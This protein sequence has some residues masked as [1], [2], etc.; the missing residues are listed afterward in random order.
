[1]AL[2]RIAPLHRRQVRQGNDVEPLAIAVIGKTKISRDEEAYLQALGAA[3]VIRGA[4][5]I[6]TD[7]KGVNTAVLAGAKTISDARIEVRKNNVFETTKWGIIYPD[8]NLEERIKSAGIIPHP[9]IIIL[10][11]TDD[12]LKFVD[13][14]VVYLAEKGYLRS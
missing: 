12:L 9:Q 11:N 3:I 5:L 13:S 2:P 14:A 7:A 8:Q 1:M 4:K 10:R 6:T